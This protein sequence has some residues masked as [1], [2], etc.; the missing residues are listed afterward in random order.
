[1]R[2]LEPLAGVGPAGAALVLLGAPHEG[3]MAA[4]NRHHQFNMLVDE[5]AKNKRKL[6]RVIY[7]C[8]RISPWSCSV[9]NIYVCLHHPNVAIF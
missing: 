9:Y 5:N 8:I 1:M 6:P 4:W 2:T 7:L 3:K